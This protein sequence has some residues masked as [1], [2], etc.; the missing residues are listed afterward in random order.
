MNKN[1]N[2]LQE[3][4]FVFGL[5]VVTKLDLTLVTSKLAGFV[6]RDRVGSVQNVVSCLCRKQ[7]VC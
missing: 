7:T 6:K 4:W 1:K 3:S 5:V 2:S